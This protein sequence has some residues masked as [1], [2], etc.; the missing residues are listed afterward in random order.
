MISDLNKIELY[1]IVDVFLAITTL[2]PR[3][4]TLASQ[5]RTILRGIDEMKSA[6]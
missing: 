2:S 6:L 3:V 4:D 1:I 5:D